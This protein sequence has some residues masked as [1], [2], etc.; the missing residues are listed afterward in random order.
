ME[1]LRRFY[2]EMVPSLSVD[3]LSVAQHETAVVSLLAANRRNLSLV[4]CAS[5]ETMRRLGIR[6]AFAFDPHF[7]EQGFDVLV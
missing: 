3:W 2:E 5:F 1:T 7:A 6:A 4:D